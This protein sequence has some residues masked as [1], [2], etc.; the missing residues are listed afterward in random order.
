MKKYLVGFFAFILAVSLSA[1]STT[2]KKTAVTSTQYHWYEVE[3]GVTTSLALN[4]GA[5]NKVDIQGA[6][7]NFTDCEGTEDVCLFGSADD[8][9]QLGAP[10]SNEGDNLIFREP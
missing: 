10:V 5:M 2:S 9:I 3:N 6:Q 4:P 8:D 7:S 1:F